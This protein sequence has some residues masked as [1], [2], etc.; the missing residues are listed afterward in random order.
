MVGY[1]ISVRPVETVRE[2]MTLRTAG[3]KTLPLPF[4]SVAFSP[5]PLFIGSHVFRILRCCPEEILQ[6][7][8][9]VYVEF[10][11]NPVAA[12]T[13]QVRVNTTRR[14]AE[15]CFLMTGLLEL[16]PEAARR[17]LLEAI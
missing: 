8:E 7:G 4:R 15:L 17:R 16:D 12:P 5:I 11:C 2:L 13:E 1:P 3:S 10:P 6:G 9:I 14:A